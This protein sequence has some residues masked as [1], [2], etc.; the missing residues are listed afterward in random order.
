MAAGLSLSRASWNRPWRGCPS[1]WRGRARAKPAAGDLRLDGVL[2][3]E[4]ATPELIERI[5]AAG[6]FGAAAPAPRFAFPAMRIRMTRP[7]GEG[8]L[9]LGLFR[10]RRAASTPSPSTPRG[11]AW[12]RCRTTRG[13]RFT[14]RPGGAEPLERSHAACSFASRMRLG[15]RRVTGNAPARA[16]IPLIPP[17]VS[18]DTVHA[19]RGPFVYRLGRQVFNLERGV[20]F[21]YGLPAT[22]R[23]WVDIAGRTPPCC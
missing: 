16:R 19:K 17:R 13:A 23:N 4:A 20:R 8:H 1:F 6:P 22:K 2:M 11:W 7:V 12:T 18:L 10:R 9:K 15:L 3:P 14:W 21:P 5:E